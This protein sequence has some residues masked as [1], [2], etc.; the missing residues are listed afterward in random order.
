MRVTGGAAQGLARVY[1]SKI[2]R[3]SDYRA[4]FRVALLLADGRAPREIAESVGVSFETVRPQIK[5]VFA[6]AN[7]KRQGELIRLLLC[8][9]REFRPYQP[10]SLWHANRRS[11]LVWMAAPLSILISDPNGCLTFQIFGLTVVSG[12]AC[13]NLE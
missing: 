10:T 3:S 6:K 9:Y 12:Q 4:E 5:S 13:K 11:P 1:S 8:A 2:R 7:V